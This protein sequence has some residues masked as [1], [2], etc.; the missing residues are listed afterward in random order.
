MSL[1]EFSYSLSFEAIDTELFP[2][3]ARVPGTPEFR[4]ALQ[5]FLEDQYRDFGGRARFVIDDR[6]R[7]VDVIWSPDPRS[8]DPAETALDHLNRR[9]YKAAIPLLEVLRHHEPGNPQHAY[10]LGMVFSDLGRL[11][12]AQSLLREAVR[13]DPTNVN[14]LVALGVAQIRSGQVDA[15]T[16]TFRTAVSAGPDNPWARRNLGGCLLKAGQ[17]LEAEEQLRRAVELQP[18]DQQSVYGLGQAL[19]ALERLPDA[20]EQYIRC[21]ELDPTS[22]V[23]N[24]AKEDRTKLAQRG[25]RERTAGVRMDAVMY[26]LSGLE[27][28]GAM[29]P[30]QVQQVGLEIAVL[31]MRGLDTNDSAQKYTLKSLPGKFSGL[32]LVCLMFLA[33]RQIAPQRDIGFDLSREYEAALGMYRAKTAE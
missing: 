12:R 23:A 22:G 19:E 13:L 20:D 6:K 32:H 24:R 14:A 9:N 29:P 8:P 17:A 4:S 30:Q 33:F 28:F 3:N 1:E 21:I 26:L 15:A 31:G 27:K 18:D 25:F 16:A 2:A 10:N 5:E 11:E 7:T